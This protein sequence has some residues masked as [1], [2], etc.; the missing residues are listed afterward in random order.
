MFARCARVEPASMRT[1]SS[2]PYLTF[3]V[4]SACSTVTPV[5]RARL[6][7]PFAPFTV[8]C[9]P[10]MVAV[11]PCGRDTGA[12][13]TLLITCPLGHDAQD[14]AA[15]SDGT[16]LFVRHHTARRR[17]DHGAHAS[18]ELRQLIL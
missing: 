15:L 17:H 10:E 13:A 5:F 14:F 11:T 4:L 16:C 9:A 8:T 18:Q 7:E 12:F 3:S 6:S 2:A 1:P